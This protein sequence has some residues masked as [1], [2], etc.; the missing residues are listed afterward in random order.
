MRRDRLFD[1]FSRTDDLPSGHAEREFSFLNR[2]SWPPFAR[3]REEIERWF[4]EFPAESRPGLAARAR[5]DDQAW[6]SV[7]WELYLHNLLHR[8]GFSIQVEP[9]L[10]GV[11]TR[12]DFLVRRDGCSVAVEA[13]T[14]LGP[15]A[16]NAALQRKN[17]VYDTI[18]RLSSPN[19]W[20]AVDV[21]EEGP[22]DLAVGRHRAA[23]ESW[24]EALDPDTVEGRLAESGDESLPRHSI[25]SGG[26]TV[27]L[28]AWP[29]AREDRGEPHRPLGAFGPG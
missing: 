9:E 26:W 27:E 6:A 11:R 28:A 21:F 4:S 8:A 15:R 19:F 23:V 20:L 14:V 25:S 18:Q 29:R 7:F 5:G 24:L 1:D 17:T 12:V 2:T 3:V 10:P 22:S 16:E 13:T